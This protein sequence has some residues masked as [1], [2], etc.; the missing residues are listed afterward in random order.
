MNIVDF[1]RQILDLEE[2]RNYWCQQAMHYQAMHEDHMESTMK[3]IKSSEAMFGKILIA[4]IDPDSGINRM[5]RA[6]LRD[7]LKGAQ[8]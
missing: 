5:H 7:P 8:A 6:V 1:A 3:S 2:E 4:A